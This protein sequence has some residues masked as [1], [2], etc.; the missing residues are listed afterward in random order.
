VRVAPQFKRFAVLGAGKTAIDSASFLLAHGVQADA[1]TWV[2]PR[3]PWLY[4][5]AFMQPGLGFFAQTI[6]G[7][8]EQFEIFATAESTVELAERMEAASLWLRLD[9]NV[10]PRMIHGATVTEAEAEALAWID[11]KVRL[12]RV[13]R[14]ERAR[15]ILQ[16]GEVSMHPETLYIDC[17]ASALARNVNDTTP[18]FEPG[19]IALQMVRIYQPTFSAAMIGHLEASLTDEA[20]KA[21]LAQ[22][23]PMTDALDDWLNCQVASLSNQAQ[24]SRNAG[25]AG[26]MSQCRLNAYSDQLAGVSPADGERWPVVD[27]L[28]KHLGPALENLQRLAAVRPH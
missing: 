3:D 8:A 12:G 14:I 20:E 15:L 21:T 28:R 5:R 1:I 2:M 13:Q 17:T 23:S 9:K 27:R 4:N 18:V 22:P 25:I 11:A 16:Q 26:W 19:K 6:G 10:W 24:W 7:L